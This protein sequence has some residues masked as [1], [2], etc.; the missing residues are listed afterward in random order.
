M[1]DSPNVVTLTE[2]FRTSPAHRPFVSSPTSNLICQSR[3]VALLLNTDIEEFVFR[4]EELSS[5]RFV[6]AAQ[7]GSPIDLVRSERAEIGHVISGNLKK[8]IGIAPAPTSYGQLRQSKN[9]M[10]HPRVSPCLKL[11]ARAVISKKS[12][13]IVHCSRKWTLLQRFGGEM[14]ETA[15][16]VF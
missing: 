5:E 1:D 3:D 14:P 10:R 12:G 8:T 13:K 15:K 7:Y 9:F 6:I 16:K 2:Y 4:R 11:P